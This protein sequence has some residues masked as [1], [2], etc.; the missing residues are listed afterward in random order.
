M[1]F[2]EIFGALF[3][4]CDPYTANYLEIQR[5]SC[6]GA[7]IIA[8]AIFLV[9]YAFKAIALMTMAKKAGQNKLVW[10]AFVPFASTYLLGK[11]AGE[12]KFFNVKIKNIGLIA[13]IVEL[14]AA[15][16]CLLSYIPQIYI[17][18]GGYY[19]LREDGLYIV[20][21]VSKIYNVANISNIIYYIFNWIEILVFVFLYIAIYRKYYTRGH[22]V[23]TILSTFLPISA[24]LLF[25]IRNNQPVDYEKYMKDRMERIRRAQQNNPYGPYGNPYNNPYNNPYSNPYN[26]Q[27]GQQNTQNSAS[28]PDDPFGEYSNGESSE[29][30]S[31]EPHS[32]YNNGND[33]DDGFFN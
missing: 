8:G 16:L 9:I 1:E 6:Y 26:N 15:A 20:D 33:D 27:Y 28:K 22:V 32:G 21:S 2:F 12:T 14:V 18:E 23:F 13:F 10:C 7:L 5:M 29:N 25:A 4:L 19:I 24:F 3:E 30:K 11:L 17:I 31:E